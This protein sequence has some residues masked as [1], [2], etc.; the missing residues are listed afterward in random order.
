MAVRVDCIAWFVT[1]I[2]A[3]GAG[4]SGMRV[5]STCMSRAMSTAMPALA[6]RQPS[7]PLSLL[8]RAAEPEEAVAAAACSWGH[9]GAGACA[10]TRTRKGACLKGLILPL[11]RSSRGAALISPRPGRTQAGTSLTDAKVTPHPAA[12][13]ELSRPGWRIAEKQEISRCNTMRCSSF[14]MHTAARRSNSFNCVVQR[15]D[16]AGRPT[17]RN[18]SWGRVNT[19]TWSTAVQPTLGGT[20]TGIVLAAPHCHEGMR[21]WRQECVAVN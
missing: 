17:V 5:C 10:S 21:R 14:Y 12:W 20:S 16:G 15:D 13:C 11:R 3:G 19:G 18:T 6:L 7:M 2:T 1:N 9:S 8:W 4:Y